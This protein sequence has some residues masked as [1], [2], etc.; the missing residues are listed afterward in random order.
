MSEAPI[1]PPRRDA[2]A[3][4]LGPTDDRVI[5]RD[6]LA[7]QTGVALKLRIG[8]RWINPLWALPVGFL[9]LVLGVAIEMARPKRFELSAF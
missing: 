6:W 1:D 2:I 4:K 5:L 7:P 8:K 9:I 3:A